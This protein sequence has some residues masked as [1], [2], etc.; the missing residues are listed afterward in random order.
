VVAEYLARRVIRKLTNSDAEE[1]M[2]EKRL[3]RKL[4]FAL[5]RAQMAQPTSFSPP[6][7][8]TTSRGNGRGPRDGG[9]R[10]SLIG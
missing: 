7:N 5:N 8:W 3:A 9:N 6:G 10:G 4:L 2:C 1:S